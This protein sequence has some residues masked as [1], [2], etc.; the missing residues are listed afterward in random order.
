MT[1]PASG[2]ILASKVLGLPLPDPA[3]SRFGLDAN[4][5]EYDESVL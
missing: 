1:S 3:F 5:V 4:W 2:E